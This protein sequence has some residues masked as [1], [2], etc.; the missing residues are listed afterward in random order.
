MSTGVR[1]T[2]MSGAGNDFVVLDQEVAR[3]IPDL[4]AWARRV[5]RRGLSVGADGVLVVGPENGA[6]RVLFLNPDGGEAFC[7]NGTRCAARFAVMRGFARERL[8]L[9]TAVG[10]VEAHVQGA[11]VRLELPGPRDLGPWEGPTLS[12]RRI[13][14]GVPHL[15]LEVEDVRSAPLARWGPELAHH[16]D[17]GLPGTNVD[18]VAP[19]GDGVLHIRTWERGVE[20]ET[21]SC[22][23][24]AVA[25]AH[26]LALRAGTAEVRV[27]PA[28]G[29]P[30]RVTLRGE[31]AAPT[32][33]LLEGDA[34]VIF[35]GTLPQEAVSGFPA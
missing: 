33:A 34:R 12:G 1:V 20:G 17:F 24:G 4:A 11:Q 23:S 25:G 18:V 7:G 29:I 21:L 35:E 28:S 14:A 8:R 26:F 9:R 5:C 10:D 2:K 31:V 6:V 30:L 27:L 13:A 22:G 16:P 3:G 19:G 32:G 15:V